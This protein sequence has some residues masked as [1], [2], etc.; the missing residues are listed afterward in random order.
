[1]KKMICVLVALVMCLGMTAPAYAT[2]SGFVPSITYK[3]NP[4]IVPVEMENGETAIGVVRDAG[5]EIVDY[6]E[7]ACLVITPIA[8]VWDE[9]K[10]VPAEV[11]QLLMFVYEELQTENMEIPYEKHE[12]DLNPD[13]MVI[14]DLFDVR[15]YCEEHKEMVEQE[16]VVFEI[17]FD[18]GI[19]PDVEIYVM[20]Y[21]EQTGEWE[22]VVKTVNNG[23]GTVTCTFEHLCAVAFSMALAAEEAPVEQAASQNLLPWILALV[24]A[25]AAFLIILIAKKKKKTAA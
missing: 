12:A 7:D 24:L 23:D 5:G 13:E 18:L 6:V 9:E 3:P 21:D 4:E 11:E 20:T 14:R 1:M 15:W 19:G 2:E 22:P 17:T 25:G 8:H 16:G 10:E